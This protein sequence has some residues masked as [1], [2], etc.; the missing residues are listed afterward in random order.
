MGKMEWKAKKHVA[1]SNCIKCYEL[2]CCNCVTRR[3]RLIIIFFFFFYFFFYF[4]SDD[5]NCALFKTLAFLR[6]IEN[7]SLF[8]S[9]QDNASQT[10]RLLLKR[11]FNNRIY[12][13]K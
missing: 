12:I 3:F 7:F 11:I 6:D 10:E 5:L 9:A 2:K 8:S 13:L 1:C 4:F